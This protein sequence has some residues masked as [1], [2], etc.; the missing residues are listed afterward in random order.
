MTFVLLIFLVVLI[1]LLVFYG[2]KQAL[3]FNQLQRLKPDVTNKAEWIASEQIM[4]DVQTHYIEA[5]HWL[6]K[7][8]LMNWKTQW[9]ESPIYFS[10]IYLKRHQDILQAQQLHPPQFVGIIRCTHQIQVRHFSH[11]GAHCLIIDQQKSRRVATY[12]FWTLE[13]HSTQDL[14]DATVVYAMA[15]DSKQ[16]RW[17][18]DRFIQELPIGWNHPDHIKLLSGLPSDIGRDN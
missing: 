2:S 1:G 13:R 7:S 6:A 15:Y 12:N 10:G 16:Q 4:T 8:V 11:D 14:G 17:K 18:I 9:S 5:N 3:W